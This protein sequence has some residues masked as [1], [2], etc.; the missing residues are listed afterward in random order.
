MQCLGDAVVMLLL[1]R[2]AIGRAGFQPHME[3]AP[4]IV[5]ADGG[6]VALVAPVQLAI[7]TRHLPSN[8]LIACVVVDERMA[9]PRA[10]RA[11]T[12]STSRSAA[13][14]YCRWH[15]L[16][17]LSLGQCHRLCPRYPFQAESHIT[18]ANLLPHVSSVVPT[19]A[20]LGRELPHAVKNVVHSQRIRAHETIRSAP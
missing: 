17:T 3:G 7:T 9:Q 6:V 16:D 19:Y 11:T 10:T 5:L 4:T 2:S 18:V 14:P 12:A 13:S 20:D 15:A 8:G 1:A